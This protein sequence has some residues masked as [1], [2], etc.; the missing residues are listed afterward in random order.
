MGLVPLP[1]VRPGFLA[2]GP[3]ADSVPGL[4]WEVAEGQRIQ[5]PSA[6]SSPP[7]ALVGGSG[8]AGWI[9]CHWSGPWGTLDGVTPKVG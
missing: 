3:M 7:W 9:P 1:G 2:A 4:T 8:E 6:P 5:Q